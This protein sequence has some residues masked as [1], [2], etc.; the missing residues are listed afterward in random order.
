M[1]NVVNFNGKPDEINLKYDS[2]KRPMYRFTFNYRHNDQY[3][4][5][6]FWALD[7][8]DALEK[9]DAMQQSMTYIGQAYTVYV[10]T[11]NVTGLK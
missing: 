4:D 3:F 9:L 10:S 11:R 6:D 2:Y 8:A 7:E 5:V 1:S